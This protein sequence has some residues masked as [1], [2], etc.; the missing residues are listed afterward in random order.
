[1]KDTVPDDVLIDAIIPE[2]KHVKVQERLLNQ[3]SN[4]T[5][6]KALSIGHQYENFQKR[7]KRIRGGKDQNKVHIKFYTIIQH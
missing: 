7:L 4:P 3:G 1:M 2:V 5:V 6:A